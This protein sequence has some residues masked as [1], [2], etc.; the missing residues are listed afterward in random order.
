MGTGKSG[1][2][3]YLIDYGLAYQFYNPRTR[4]HLPYRSGKKLIGTMR[5]VS[6]NTHLGLEQ[7]RRDDLEA[8]G[9]VLVYVGAGSLPW[10]KVAA[11][12]KDQRREMVKEL[13]LNTSLATLC[14]GLPE[15]FSKYISYC[16]QLQFAEDPD[17]NYLKKLFK[18]LLMKKGE[19][20]DYKYDWIIKPEGIENNKKTSKDVAAEEMKEEQEKRKHLTSGDRIKEAKEYYLKAFISEPVEDEAKVGGNEGSPD[21][22]N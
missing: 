4:E 1:D 22:L 13:K 10:Q 19:F 12:T 6:I 11:E 7:S 21:T 5:Y 15:E 8:L 9:Y 17:Y 3:V 2:L 14:K 20:Y 16:R 18:T